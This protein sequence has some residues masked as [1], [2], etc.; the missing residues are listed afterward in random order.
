M[1]LA[2]VRSNSMITNL[3][4]N[5][6]AHIVYV[7]LTDRKRH[8]GRAV[9]LIARV[10][11]NGKRTKTSNRNGGGTAVK[12]YGRSPNKQFFLPSSI[13]ERSS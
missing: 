12:N 4:Q 7:N 8:L 11:L 6:M 2:V 5:K 13:H 3:V 9:T 1:V 10:F